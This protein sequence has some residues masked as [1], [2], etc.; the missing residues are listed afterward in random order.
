MNSKQNY[1]LTWQ[2]FTLNP[3]EIT[4]DRLWYL[5]NK[6]W[7]DWDAA[8]WFYS[9]SMNW[10]GMA[11]RLH[12]L[13]ESQ[14]MLRSSCIWFHFTQSKTIDWITTWSPQQSIDSSALFDILICLSF[15]WANHS[16]TTCVGSS[17]FYT[18]PLCTWFKLCAL[19][20]LHRCWGHVMSIVINRR[21]YLSVLFD[22]LL[23]A[24]SLFYFIVARQ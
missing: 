11:I 17:T 7:I 3:E 15:A 12:N 19:A 8:A 18:T 14:N 6:D 5:S 9:F 16:V 13:D 23:L 1:R 24:R 4:V 10:N 2:L 21:I 20:L 22:E